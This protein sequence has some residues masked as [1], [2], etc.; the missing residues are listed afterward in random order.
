M[1]TPTLV[2]IPCFSGAPWDLEQLSPL[3]TWPLRTMR[4]P[5]SLDDVEAYVDFVLGEVRE[6]D[7][8]V[9][10][11]DSFGAVVALGTAIRRPRG[12]VGLVLSGGFAAAPV[13]NRLMRAKI[14]A[15]R[16]FPG[17]LY[18]AITLRMHARSLASPYDQE[19]Q[20]PWTVKDSR[21][22]FLENTPFR[23]YV[24]R[25][26]AAF[27]IDY[28][29]RLDRVEVPTLVMTPS[30]DKLIGPQ[31]ARE[32]VEGIPGAREAVLEDTGHMF[33]FSH[34]VTYAR[35]IGAFLESDVRVES[36]T[37]SLGAA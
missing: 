22:L 7:D 28:R 34:P 23:S 8:F 12:L 14:R 15:A 18:R 25:A 21:G 36:G 5:E 17:P 32:L 24:A 29:D 27:S 13:E 4:L 33:R 9:L 16:F 2:T 6:I 19:G 20:V 35:E 3:R 10:I 11:G 37:T 26:R 30:Y 1:P 31:A